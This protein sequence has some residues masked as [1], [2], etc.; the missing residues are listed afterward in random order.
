MKTW[1]T[2]DLLESCFKTSCF[3]KEVLWFCPPA[4]RSLGYIAMKDFIFKDGLWI[5]KGQI[6]TINV[7]SAHFWP[8]EW[9]KA[10]EFLPERFDPNSPLFKTPEGK[11]WIPESFCPFIFGPRQCPG[12]VLALLELK[13]LLITVLLKL[14]WKVSPTDIKNEDLIFTLM[15]PH[16]LHLQIE[17][18]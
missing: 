8:T 16:E 1:L 9:Q 15:S 2:G 17:T 3:I 12:K 11:N 10:E 7:L 14:K 18:N 6:I 4:S 5:Q 13:V